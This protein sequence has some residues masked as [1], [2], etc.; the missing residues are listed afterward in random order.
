MTKNWWTKFYM[1]ARRKIKYDETHIAS[2]A[3][4][5]YSFISVYQIFTTNICTIHLHHIAFDTDRHKAR[6]GATHVGPRRRVKSG[7]CN[8]ERSIRDG[9]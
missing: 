6:L 8:R 5:L 2:N 4:L 9:V 3:N 7:W 1:E